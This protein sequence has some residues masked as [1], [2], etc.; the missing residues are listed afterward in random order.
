MDFVIDSKALIGA[1]TT[2]KGMY[3]QYDINDLIYSIKFSQI[4]KCPPYL[5]S[6][7]YSSVS[8]S[9]TALRKDNEGWLDN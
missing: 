1:S 5:F 7:I 2:L 8:L 3:V 9:L 6:V 4:L